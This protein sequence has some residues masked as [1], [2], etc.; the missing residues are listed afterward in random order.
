MPSADWFLREKIQ[1]CLVDMY[2]EARSRVEQ[3]I[4]ERNALPETERIMDPM[5]RTLLGVRRRAEPEHYPSPG[6][7][8]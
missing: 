3:K 1:T 7:P 2:P 8:T 5:L 4:V 6:A